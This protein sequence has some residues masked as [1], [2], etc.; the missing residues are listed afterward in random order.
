MSNALAIA[1]VTATLDTLLTHGLGMD[2]TVKPLDTAR[3]SNNNQVNLFLYQTSI[4]A[5]W[6]NQDM[7]YQVKAGETGQPPLPLCLYYLV[8]AYGQGDD[9]TKAHQVLGRAMSILHDHPL[10]G[11]KEIKDATEANV[12]GSNLHEQIERVRITP[13]HLSVEEL[14]KL[15]TIFQTHYR[16]SAAYEVSVVLIESTLPTRTPLPVLTRGKDDMGVQTVLG[17]SPLLGEIRMPLSG[18]FVTSDPPTLQE[19]QLTKA[20]PSAQLGDEVALIGEKLTGDSVWVAFERP[21]TGET[22][23]PNILKKSAEVIILKLPA[24]GDAAAANLTAGF[25]LATVIA[26]HASEPDRFSNALAVAIAP[27]ITQINGKNLP[28]TPL[29]SV[30]RTNIVDGLG[31]ATLEITGNLEVLPEQSAVL[32]IGDRSVSAESHPA[33]T[34]K[35][36]FIVREI[37][38]GTYRLRL[39]VDGVDSHLI[40]RSSLDKP[41]FDDALQVVIK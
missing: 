2:V 18:K 36:K 11:A 4:N 27:K 3:Q 37:E 39:R 14:S 19:I 22:F 33:K 41:K 23:E 17:G 1:A 40:D 34:N 38:A 9:Q 8:T 26:S 13:H 25:H 30:N 6:R 21:R 12:Q 15:W 29:V 35:L 20:L 5:A 16:I 24:P 28:A 31:E 32:L 10:L 7:P